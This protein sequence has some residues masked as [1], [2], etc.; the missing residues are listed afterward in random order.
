MP[1]SLASCSIYFADQVLSTVVYSKYPAY[2]LSEPAVRA[3]GEL[4]KSV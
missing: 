2:V 3:V 4:H 1:L